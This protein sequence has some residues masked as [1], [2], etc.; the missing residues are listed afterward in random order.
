MW[1][2]KL[3]VTNEQTRKTNK[4]ELIDTDNSMV[5]TIGKGG[6]GSKG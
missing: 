4:Q 1:D 2:I 5:I 3:K 6:E